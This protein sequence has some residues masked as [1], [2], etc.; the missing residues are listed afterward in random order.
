VLG[1]GRQQKSYL[2]VRDCVEAIRSA[3]ASHADR[4]GELGVYNL[5]TDDTVVVDDSIAMICEHMGV[6]PTLEYTGGRRG[7]AG[8]SPLIHLDC[9][10]IRSLG[11]APTLSIRDAIGRT[12]EWFDANPYAWRARVGAEAGVL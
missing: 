5:G 7:W 3:V 12:L 11:W 2:Y 1:D 6:E 10:R 8:D 4:P 9:T